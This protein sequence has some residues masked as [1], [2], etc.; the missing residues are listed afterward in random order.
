[1]YK[2]ISNN[3]NVH[4]LIT[5]LTNDAHIKYLDAPHVYTKTIK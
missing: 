4:L 1:M 5:L 3:A 2:I